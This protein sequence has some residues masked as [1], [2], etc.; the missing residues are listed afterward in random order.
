MINLKKVG[1][2]KFGQLFSAIPETQGQ[3]KFNKS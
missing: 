1:T 2:L 3:V